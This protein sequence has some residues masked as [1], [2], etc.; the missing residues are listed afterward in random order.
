MA[1]MM[2]NMTNVFSLSLAET[3]RSELPGI[4]AKSINRIARIAGKKGKN[5]KTYI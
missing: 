3:L 4:D 2:D 1:L 5:C